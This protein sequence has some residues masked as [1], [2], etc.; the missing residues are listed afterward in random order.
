MEFFWSTFC[1]S[2]IKFFFDEKETLYTSTYEVGRK[3]Y[4]FLYSCSMFTLYLLRAEKL[5]ELRYIGE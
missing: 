1:D 3:I 5:F 2:I 4:N